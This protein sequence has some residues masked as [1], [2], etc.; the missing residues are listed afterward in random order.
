VKLIQKECVSILK[1]Q[2]LAGKAVIRSENSI[3]Q[4]PMA[5][6]IFLDVMTERGFSVSVDVQKVRI[7]D[8]IKDGAIHCANK[9][10]YEFHFD[11]PK[12]PIRTFQSS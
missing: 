8:S 6:D 11:F 9:R 7:P 1:Q 4:R 10:L 2:A 12:P 5:L 3:F